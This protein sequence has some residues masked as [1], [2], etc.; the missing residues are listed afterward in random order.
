M[1][2]KRGRKVGKK[3]ARAPAAVAEEAHS[4]EESP[5]SPST[6]AATTPEDQPEDD[7]PVPTA[8]V[9]P[10]VPEPTPPTPP[11]S[12]PP[13]KPSAPAPSSQTD[14]TY[15]KPKV[16][17]VYGRVKLKFKSSKAIEPPPPQKTSS[18]AQT[19]AADA[20]KPGNAAVPEAVTEVAT[21]KVAVVTDG[22]QT[23]GQAPE[24]SGSDKEKVV[25]KVGTIKIKPVVLPSSIESSTPDRKTDVEDEPPPSKLENISENK[26]ADDVAEPRSS[27]ESEEQQSTPERQRDD[28]E[29]AAA[30]EVSWIQLKFCMRCYWRVPDLY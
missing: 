25:K 1:K 5:S 13:Q 21:E 6:E 4:P 15:N 12:Q 20:G 24:M 3:S 8:T 23:E 16:G 28:K 17:A 26:E 7:A 27:Q 30:L 9:Q 10:A 2:R 19:P 22:Q 29:L 14:M 18:E 11:P